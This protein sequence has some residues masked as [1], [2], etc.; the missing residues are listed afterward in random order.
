MDVLW[1]SSLHVQSVDSSTC[2]IVQIDLSLDEFAA[3]FPNLIGGS[4][5]L[6]GSNCTTNF[7]QN[8]GDFSSENLEGRNIFGLL[9]KQNFEENANVNDIINGINTT[10]SAI[11]KTSTAGAPP[12]IPF[13]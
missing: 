2:Q 4:A 5:D 6:D 12:K 11:N 13:F 8:Y 10:S 7:V 1:S 3:K 9:P